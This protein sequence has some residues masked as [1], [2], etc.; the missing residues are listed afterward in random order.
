MDESASIQAIHR[1]HSEV[2]VRTDSELLIKSSEWIHGWK[3]NGWRTA[4]GEPVKNRDLLEQMDSL[5]QNVLV[6]RRA[7]SSLPGF[8]I[9]SA[10]FR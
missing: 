3:R 2:T 5:R 1:G 6:G 10:R 7:A 8:H 9:H 4:N